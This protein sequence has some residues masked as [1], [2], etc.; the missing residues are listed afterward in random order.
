MRAQICE[1]VDW[2]AI[3]NALPAR[4][5]SR[6]RD[7][8]RNRES[9]TLLAFPVDEKTGVVMSREIVHALSKLRSGSPAQIVCLAYNYTCEAELAL[10]ERSAIILRV[11]DFFWTD[12]SLRAIRDKH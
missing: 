8:P 6:S 3:V 1:E 4:F 12:A 2:D 10:S 9:Y 11:R 7:I 5:K